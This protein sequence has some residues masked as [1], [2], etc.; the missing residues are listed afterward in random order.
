LTSFA[1]IPS[2]EAIRVG[3]HVAIR[4]W[5]RRPLTGTVIEVYDPS[6]PSIPHGDNPYAFSIRLE[7][8]DVL[9][10]GQPSRRVQLIARAEGRR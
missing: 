7:N 8:G 5:L 6:R 2:G 4:R 9:F 3:D 10:F 1:Y